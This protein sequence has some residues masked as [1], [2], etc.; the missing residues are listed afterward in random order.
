[1]FNQKVVDQVREIE[2]GLRDRIWEVADVELE[3]KYDVYHI[4][5]PEGTIRFYRW[6]TNKT[7]DLPMEKFF[8]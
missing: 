8:D 7:V 6:R 5:W 4:I 2:A 1:M 3:E